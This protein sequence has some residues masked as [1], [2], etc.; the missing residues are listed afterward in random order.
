ML[1]K[2]LKIFKQKK[3]AE[4][5][6]IQKKNLTNHLFKILECKEKIQIIINYK[7]I[8]NEL[9]IYCEYELSEKDFY[10][11]GMHPELIDFF[12]KFQ[13]IKAKNS[14][15]EYGHQFIKSYEEIENQE[16]IIIGTD[17]N[18]EFHIV[19]K[20]S[21]FIDYSHDIS[22]E[23]D[24]SLTIYYQIFM[25]IIYDLIYDDNISLSKFIDVLQKIE[26]VSA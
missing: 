24:E 25:D 11:D 10:F 3:Q 22:D 13:Y 15:D 7:K 19:R 9:L 6:S 18:G 2:V 20:N 4:N 23:I 1:E 26:K 21:Q 14:L 12:S 16:Y 8:F 5:L 17:N